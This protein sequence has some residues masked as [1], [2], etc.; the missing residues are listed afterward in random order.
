MEIEICNNFSFTEGILP[1]WLTEFFFCQK[2]SQH[3]K[4]LHKTASFWA[5]KELSA[6]QKG[7][8]L[9]EKIKLLQI[10]ISSILGILGFQPLYKSA[11]KEATICL[12]KRQNSQGNDNDSSPIALVLSALY[13]PKK[14]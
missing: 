8:I 3:P 13:F 7:K 9:W 1:I 6:I 10:S 4:P 12:P 2:K 5:N 11:C 14:S